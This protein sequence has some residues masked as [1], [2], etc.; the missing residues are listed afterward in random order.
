MEEDLILTLKSITQ[1][2]CDAFKLSHNQDRYVPPSANIAADENTWSRQTTPATNAGDEERGDFSHKI[3]LTFNDGHKLGWWFGSSR[4]C[5][6]LLGRGHISN[7]HF[8][9]TFDDKG[10]L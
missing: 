8:C 9:I 3:Q 10:R 2:A 5:D 7:R 4:S 6:I 1:R